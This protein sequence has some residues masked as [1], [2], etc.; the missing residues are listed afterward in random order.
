MSIERRYTLKQ[1]IDQFF[2]DGPLTVASLRTEIRKGRLV[3]ERIAGKLTVT[4][5]S[6]ALMLEQCREEPA[7]ST[8]AVSVTSPSDRTDEENMRLAYAA[9]KA[10]VQRIK[11]GSRRKG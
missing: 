4:E 9:A 2:P 11:Q 1:A 8:H 3:A 6:L 7:R 5:A 10:V